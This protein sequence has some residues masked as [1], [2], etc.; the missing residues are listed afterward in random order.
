MLKVNNLS[1]YYATGKKPVKAI[2]DV[3]LELNRGE[4]LGL[5]G[6]SG[7]GK[8]AMLLTFMRLVPYPGKIISGEILFQGEDL[9]K[10]PGRE[11]R[12]LRGSRISMIF[13]DPM[14]TLN[15]VFKVGEQIRETLRVHNMV[16]K[17][18]VFG[19]MDRARKRA[20][21]EMV[22]KLMREV[23]IPS[24][25]DRYHEFPHE[26]SGGMQQRAL[27]AAALSCEP[28]LLLADEPTT[29]LDVTIQAQIVEL[30]KKINRERGT[31]IILVTHDLAM[32][33][34]F[35]HRIAVMYAGRIV[36]MGQTDE[37]ISNPRHPYT[38]GLLQSIPRITARKQKINPIAGTVP[39]LANLPEGCSFYPRCNKQ[40]E[41]C[42]QEV[43]L[44]EVMPGHQVRCVLY[45]E[46]LRAVIG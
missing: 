33:A 38:V 35:C 39:D 43:E 5:V 26:Y 19:F 30:L 17:T 27:I 28:D 34:E 14:T 6:E 18:A 13:Q 8:S 2:Q 45:E 1:M 12:R 3:S 42:L 40:R 23:G 29:A 44:A 10:K 21:M 20:E 9:L 7:C 41:Q 36:E 37:V 15:P 31:A 11:M 24:E 25:E 32:A 22:F 4:I 16:N 46:Q